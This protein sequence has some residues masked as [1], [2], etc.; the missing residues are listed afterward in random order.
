MVNNLAS[1]S[2]SQIAMHCICTIVAF[3]RGWQIDRPLH[4]VRA[5]NSMH[6]AAKPSPT[7][8]YE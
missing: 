1:S 3:D 6:D 7:F 8:A 2:A 5:Q 4:V